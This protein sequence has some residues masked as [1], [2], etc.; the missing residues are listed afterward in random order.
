[1]PV[2]Y[3]SRIVFLIVGDITLKYSS[4]ELNNKDE[5]LINKRIFDIYYNAR[6]IKKLRETLKILL[7]SCAY[8][9]KN[10]ETQL[11]RF[12]RINVPEWEKEIVK[13]AYIVSRAMGNKLLQDIKILLND[14]KK[15]EREHDIKE[16]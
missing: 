4:I 7:S 6:K 11:S 9:D 5:I 1:M 16:G 13:D 10:M 14:L 8:S 3:I 2:T 15:C 12:E